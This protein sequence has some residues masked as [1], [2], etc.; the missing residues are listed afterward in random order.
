MVKRSWLEDLTMIRTVESDG[1]CRNRDYSAQ[2]R[3][4]QL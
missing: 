4:V 1:D 2:H 3:V